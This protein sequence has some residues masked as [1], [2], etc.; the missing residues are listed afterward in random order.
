VE[1][2]L[3]EIVSKQ[4]EMNTLIRSL[5]VLSEKDKKRRVGYLDQFFRAAENRERLL[6]RFDGRCID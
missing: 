5:P 3:D 2:A 1:Q 6:K 4:P